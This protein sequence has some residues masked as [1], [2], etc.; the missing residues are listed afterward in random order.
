MKAVSVDFASHDASQNSW[1]KK[2]FL[3][4]AGAWHYITLDGGVYKADK[5]LLGGVDKGYFADPDAL[6]T[7]Y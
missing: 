4:N 3:D 5:T 2:W 7:D 6:I 1:E